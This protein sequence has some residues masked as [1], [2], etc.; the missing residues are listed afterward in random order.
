M[1]NFGVFWLAWSTTHP[2]LF[3]LQIAIT[4]FPPEPC[5]E[6][7]ILHGSV[8]GQLSGDAYFGHVTCHPGYQLVGGTGKVRGINLAKLL[9][10]R[11][12]KGIVYSKDVLA[13]A[14]SQNLV[15]ID[16]PQWPDCKRR[17]LPDS[18]PP[19]LPQVKCRRGRW[20]PME[21]PVCAKPGSCSP[22]PPLPR[23]RTVPVRGARGAAVRFKCRW[24]SERNPQTVITFLKQKDYVGKNIFFLFFLTLKC[25][26]HTKIK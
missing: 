22:L 9:L 20:S 14:W 24:R 11:W 7:T 4:P 2:N 23:G 25:V 8:S 5:S 26:N 12:C 21:L 1:G 15:A 17:C 6:P 13:F 16:R 18:F 3:F 19:P 10:F